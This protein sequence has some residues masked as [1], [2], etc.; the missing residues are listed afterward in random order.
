[1]T[2]PTELRTDRLLLRPFSLSDV[3]DVLEYGSDPEWAAFF[4]PYDRGG[5]EDMIAR[6]VLTSWKEAPWF[7]L[8]LDGKVIGMAALSLDRRNVAE[9]SYEVARSHWGKGL[10][11]EAARAV[12]DWGFRETGS[13]ERWRRLPTP[14]TGSRG[15]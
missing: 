6:A 13:R 15:A 5:T 2:K 12:V 4:D 7:A 14:E 10:A 11:P 1:M 8:E 3:D 9:L